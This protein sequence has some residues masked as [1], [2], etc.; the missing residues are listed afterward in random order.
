ML[1]NTLMFLAS[2]P[3]VYL[4][5]ALVLVFTNSPPQLNDIDKPD[6]KTLNFDNVNS[7]DMQHL[8][9]QQTLEISNASPIHYRFYQS[10][11]ATNR[12]IVLIHGS[13]WHSMQYAQMANYLADN[14]LGHVVTPDLR[15]HGEKPQRRGDVD[16]IGQL[17]DDL[18]A[19]VGKLKDDYE[20]ANVIFGGHSS[21]GGLVIR[22]AG[23]KHG[24]IANGW[25]LMA[26]FLKYNA[27]TMRKNSGGWANVL[28]RRTIGLSMLNAIG[29]TALNHLT[30]ISFNMPQTVLTGPL[31]HTVTLA[32]S[33]RLNTSYA[34][35]SDYEKDIAAMSKPILLLAGSNDEAFR[36]DMYEPTFSALNKHGDYKILS[37]LGHLNLTHDRA[38]FKAI[39]NWLSKL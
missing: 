10:K 22:M 2:V 12:L 36:A 24:H 8:A 34:P 35:R 33:Y 23:G 6:V 3:I 19:L 31:G 14:G 17:E 38:T 15:G 32:Y 1:K 7:Q 30:S 16:Y 25:L 13:A 29:I 37:G 39:E 28:V 26:P 27:P 4:I 18:A 9:P 5:I 20:I 21:G 11:I